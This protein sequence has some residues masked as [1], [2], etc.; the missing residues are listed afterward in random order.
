MGISGEL[1]GRAV[2]ELKH[3]GEKTRGMWEAIHINQRKKE[4]SKLYRVCS[5]TA[6]SSL[7]T[8]A[9]KGKKKHEINK[10]EATLSERIVLFFSF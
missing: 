7:E 8:K 4:N 10:N 1:T 5:K 3:E 9:R 2:F 6:E